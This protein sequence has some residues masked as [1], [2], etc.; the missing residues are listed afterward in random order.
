MVR[1]RALHAKRPM[2]ELRSAEGWKSP[3]LR[4]DCDGRPDQRKGRP[5]TPGRWGMS[6]QDIERI[7][8]QGMAAW[9]TGD[10]DAW[11]TLLADDFVWYDW[12]QPEPIRDKGAARKY[13]SSWRKAFPDMN[14]KQT[15]RVDGDQHRPH[16]DGR[17]GDPAHE[18][19]RDRSRLLHRLHPRREGRRVS[20][21]PGRGRDHDADGVHAS[22]VERDQPVPADSRRHGRGGKL[23]CGGG[24]GC[25]IRQ[26]PTQRSRYRISVGPGSSTRT[27]WASSP[28]T[29][30]RTA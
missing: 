18:Q 11:V 15:A 4:L 13:F 25:S 9:E 3:D 8:D 30:G 26:R 23:G 12:T 5:S 17:Q 16:G 28:W 29:S 20:Q 10:A 14:S 21:P 7:D 24:A 1:K 6:K 2:P 27:P 19:D 22:H